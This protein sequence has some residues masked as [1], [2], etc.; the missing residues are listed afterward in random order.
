M[1]GW[2]SG[3]ERREGLRS[4]PVAE[5]RSSNARV[6]LEAGLALGEWVSARSFICAI[7]RGISRVHNQQEKI[8]RRL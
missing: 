4:R 3:A 8:R 5:L 1:D 7:G 2:L 6:A